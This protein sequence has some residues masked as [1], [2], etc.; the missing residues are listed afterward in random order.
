MACRGKRRRASW[1]QSVIDDDCGS[2]A[3]GAAMATTVG[4]V[5]SVHAPNAK[6]FTEEPWFRCIYGAAAN[7]VRGVLMLSTATRT[8]SMHMLRSSE[9]FIHRLADTKTLIRRPHLK[10]QS[11]SA[12]PRPHR[13]PTVNRTLHRVSSRPVPTRLVASLSVRRIVRPKQ[14]ADF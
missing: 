14:R 6:K 9:Q 13:M 11:D 4:S 7:N 5:S 12:T 10:R 8:R 1:P 3:A 2:A